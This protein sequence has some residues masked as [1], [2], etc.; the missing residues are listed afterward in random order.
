MNLISCDYC[1]VVLDQ[2]KLEFPVVIENKDG[3]INLGKAAWD[4]GNYVPKIPC[5]ACSL[6]VL[7]KS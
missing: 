4:G 1:G 3:S 2:N 5:P 7:K 6:D